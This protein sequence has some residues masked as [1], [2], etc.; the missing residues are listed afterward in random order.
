MVAQ[1]SANIA[2]CVVDAKTAV[3]QVSANTTDDVLPI[4][5]ETMATNYGM[6]NDTGCVVQYV[7]YSKDRIEHS[8]VLAST[9]LL[10]MQSCIHWIIKQSI[11]FLYKNTD[12]Q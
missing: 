7:G 4:I 5:R 8:Y 12:V 11:D 1:K 10:T 6:Y 3:A 2:D 9:L